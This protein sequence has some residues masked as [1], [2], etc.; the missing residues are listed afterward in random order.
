MLLSQ[1]KQQ[2]DLEGIAIR[3]GAQPAGTVPRQRYS[4]NVLI[5][6][7]VNLVFEVA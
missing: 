5:R 4:A 2:F 7:L 6:H 1:P 3:E